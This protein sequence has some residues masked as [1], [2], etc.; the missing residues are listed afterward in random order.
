MTADD[1]AT[2]RSELQT[3]EGLRLRPYLDS[4]GVITIGYG[5]KITEITP[6]EAAVLLQQD[7]ETHIADLYKAYPYVQN[8]DGVRQIVLGNMAYNLGVP[9]L[10]QFVGMWDAIQ[11]GDFQT[12]AAEMLNSLWAK[13]V[14]ARATRLA[15]SMASGELK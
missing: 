13:E 12:A 9:R 3:D 14:G 10:S 1:F 2:L 7:M 6:G 4:L 5:H 8:L 15:V 11:R